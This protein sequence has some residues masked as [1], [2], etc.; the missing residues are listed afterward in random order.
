MRTLF[1]MLVLVFGVSSQALSAELTQVKFW[2]HDQAKGKTGFVVTYTSEPNANEEARAATAAVKLVE[3]EGGLSEFIE[4]IPV[5]TDQFEEVFG[6][7]NAMSAA[8]CRI[9][10]VTNA[11]G[12]TNVE[13]L[14]FSDGMGTTETWSLSTFKKPGPLDAAK[15]GAIVRSIYRSQDWVAKNAQFIDVQIDASFATK[16]EITVTAK[17]RHTAN[18]KAVEAV[19]SSGTLK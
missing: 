5:T 11:Q 8:Q 13:Y 1:C 15:Y 14:K 12:P 4:I 17:G 9:V 10:W 6:V 7:R 2:K 19:Y 18:V 16:L 3:V